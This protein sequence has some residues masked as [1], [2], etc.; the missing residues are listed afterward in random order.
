MPQ[1]NLPGNAPRSPGHWEA[2]ACGKNAVAV[3]KIPKDENQ[4][5]IYLKAMERVKKDLMDV[6]QEFCEMGIKRFFLGIAGIKVTESPCGQQSVTSPVM[7]GKHAVN[8]IRS[9]VCERLGELV[10]DQRWFPHVTLFKDRQKIQ[11]AAVGIPFG[12]FS[13]QGISFRKRKGQ[14]IFDTPEP[15]FVISLDGDDFTPIPVVTA[16]PAAL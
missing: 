3:V 9:L 15:G 8:I 12:T 13:V 16:A 2:C 6:S 11:T 5:G 7:L 1:L 10:T 14:D 4:P